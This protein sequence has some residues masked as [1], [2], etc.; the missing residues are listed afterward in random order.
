MLWISSWKG[1]FWIK[2]YPDF[3]HIIQSMVKTSKCKLGR[4]HSLRHMI[5]I[6]M[7]INIIYHHIYV[8]YLQLY[9]WNK[10]CFQVIE[11][12]SYSVF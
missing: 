3:P 8:G 12:C 1:Q 5:M 10:P 4:I 6:M 2:N 7:I 11:R 9:T